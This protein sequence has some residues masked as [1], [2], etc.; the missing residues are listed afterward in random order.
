MAK[1]S[2]RPCPFC[3]N[4]AD[5]QEH[6]SFED[7]LRFE[8]LG[9]RTIYLYGEVNDT[10][11]RAVRA[12][13]EAMARRGKDPVSVVI[14]SPGG[15]VVDGLDIVSSIRGLQRAGIEVRASVHGEACSM[16]AVIAAACDTCAIDAHARIMWHGITMMT[17]GDRAD[18]RAVQKE[19]D[20][21]AAA[22]VS[23]LVARAHNRQ[24]RLADETVVR[25]IVD[26]KRPLY[27]AA[28]EALEAGIVDEVLS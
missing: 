27:I 9:A 7:A 26:D 23:I 11:S 14:D 24:S 8:A 12:Q 19:N 6:S 5:D 15:S 13:A 16:G 28:N 1:H 18:Q 3:G 21:M 25:E 22:L 4:K 20:R 10:M 17:F 2:S